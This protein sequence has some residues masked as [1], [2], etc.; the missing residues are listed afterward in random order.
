MRRSRVN[1]NKTDAK[2]KGA[3][4]M[5]ASRL[6][7]V[8]YEI[9]AVLGR[10]GTALMLEEL[11]SLVRDQFRSRS[12]TELYQA[13][14]RMV[15]D[16]A[17]VE[18]EDGAYRLSAGA[19]WMTGTVSGTRAGLVFFDPD[20]KGEE[21]DGEV[22]YV[23]PQDQAEG[24]F[25]GDRVRA[26][27]LGYDNRGRVL[28]SIREVVEHNTKEIVGTVEKR[29][30]DFWLRSSDPKVH[31]PVKLSGAGSIPGQGVVAEIISQPQSG[32]PARAQVKEILGSAD[33]ASVEIE[34]AVRRFGMPS[35]FAADVQAE[36][37]ALP[38]R[39]LKKDAARRVDLRDIAFVTIDGEDARDFDDA[40][41]CAP[42]KEGGWRLLVAIADV[43]W[44]VKP[45]SALDR[46]AQ[47]RLTSVY[48]PRRVI[49]MLPVEL[50]NG[51][52]SLNPDVDRC[53]MVCDAI[54]TPE[55][56]IRA[57]QFYPGLIHSHAR[58]TYTQVW[59]ALQGKEEGRL[60]LGAVL[61]DVENLYRLFKA[62]LAERRR[63]GAINFETKETQIVT[64]DEGRITGIVPR[65]H[66]D[67]HR[68]IE[69]SMLVANTCA[70]DFIIRRKAEGLFRI[71]AG[72]APDRL[73]QLRTVLAGFKLK[74]GGGAKPTP[75]DYEAV[76]REV[77]GKPEEGAVQLSLLTSMSRA[78]YSPD[79]IGHFGLAYEAYTHFT[80][81]IR[82][83]PDLLVHRVI[84]GILSRRRYKP[85]IAVADESLLAAEHSGRKKAA[86]SAAGA[87]PVNAPGPMHE[88][89]AALGRMCSAAERRADEASLD[90]TAWLKCRYMEAF[91]GKSFAGTVT[92]VTPNGVYVTLDDLF[93]EGFVHVSNLGW[94]YFVYDAERA[95]LEGSA[96]GEVIRAGS[97]MEVVVGEIDLDARRIE[98]R[99]KDVRRRRN[100]RRNGWR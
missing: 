52:C 100:S 99:R 98:F 68:L 37:E 33:D 10:A 94:D 5:S 26:V 21:A 82:R 71:H 96:S 28:V 41:W 66:N 2:G 80:S 12:R 16:G 63:R 19:Q 72:P 1:T 38:L 15:E 61:P 13:L 85:A 88:T 47:E 3:P 45:G 7:E 91:E 6:S 86:P 75:A 17:V 79:E 56:K 46:S 30:D 39:V 78:V 55:G 73:A 84:R 92:G 54:I 32:V 24:V 8:A 9:E 31:V 97:A 93:V 74:L 59:D 14:G 48:F 25:P 53:T 36:A 87:E 50:S 76:M 95:R 64:D 34:M 89:W 43:S 65:D 49:P 23:L 22:S 62:L 42:L 69:E 18:T 57:Y 27:G 44:Y 90:V 77:R 40:V 81:P 51:L 60:A 35:D 4:R 11:A 67:A 29:G 20:E 83:Y 58:L 70:A